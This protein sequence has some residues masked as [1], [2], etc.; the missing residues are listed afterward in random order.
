MSTTMTPEPVQYAAPS[1][2]KK[3][4]V[5]LIVFLAV[6]IAPFAWFTYV[7]LNQTLTG[8]IIHHGTYTSVDLKAMGNFPFDGVNGQLTDIPE[9]YRN[10]DGKK[11][12]L[13]G[14]MWAGNSASSEVNRFEFVYNISKCCFNGPPLVQERVFAG[15]PNN[16]AVPYYDSL[17]R[18][19]G[20]LHVRV[21]KDGGKIQALYLLEVEQI[22]PV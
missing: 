8:G 14:F 1:R 12:E 9:R 20:T 19:T 6:V 4:N 3:L 5:R 7:F 21:I 10:L 11:V 13:E 18:L 16:G 15:V 17:C 2:K 22:Q